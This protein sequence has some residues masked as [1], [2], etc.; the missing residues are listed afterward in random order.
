MRWFILSIL[1]VPLSVTLLI[2]TGVSQIIDRWLTLPGYAGLHS[3]ELLP[4]ALTSVVGIWIA[5]R[6]Y[7]ATRNRKLLIVSVLLNLAYGAFFL[8]ATI[9]MWGGDKV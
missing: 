2:I 6:G 3:I 4:S 7:R 5:W 8:A 1:L 9:S